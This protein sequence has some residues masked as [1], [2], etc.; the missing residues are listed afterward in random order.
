MRQLLDRMFVVVV[1]IYTGLLLLCFIAAQVITTPE[2]RGMVAAVLALLLFPA[3]V[4]LPLSLLLRHL[5]LAVL[6]AIPAAIWIINYLPLFAHRAVAAPPGLP[7]LTVVAFNVQ[8]PDADEVHALVEIIQ[9]INADIVGIS[10]LSNAAARAFETEL[11]QIYPYR[12][13]Y[14]DEA[15]DGQG[16]MSRFPITGQEYWR[17][18]EW[19]YGHVRVEVDLNGSTFALYALHVIIPISVESGLSL[20]VERHSEIIADF[21]NRAALETVPVILL[22][23][24]NMTPQFDEYQY[25][26]QVYTDT[27]RAVGE[28][29]LGFTYP[30]QAFLPLLR[31]DYIF[32]DPAFQSLEARV[33]PDSGSSDHFPVWT[34]LALQIQAETSDDV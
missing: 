29:G 10:E 16:V 28:P 9:L 3:L 32:S 12:A 24:F 11:N 26:T 23:D 20:K 13:F 1:I 19:P 34:R 22:G 21:L 5:R 30:A 14:P 31:L 2:L 4:L 6:V 27:F 25:I 17:G 18:P 8:T 15:Y 7:E 33:W